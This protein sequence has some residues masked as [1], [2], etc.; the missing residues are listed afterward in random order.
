MSEKDNEVIQY[1]I[2]ESSEYSD[3]IEDF[4]ERRDRHDDINDQKNYLL[5]VEKYMPKNYFSIEE[6]KEKLKDLVFK[7]HSDKRD[8]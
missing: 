8:E 5:R 2:L 7:S 1:S 6:P 4:L 3:A